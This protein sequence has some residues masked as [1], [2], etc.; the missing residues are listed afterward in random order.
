MT[1]DIFD[2]PTT[3]TVIVWGISE[4][5]KKNLNRYNMGNI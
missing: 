4:K 3:S 5:K 2:K 1:W